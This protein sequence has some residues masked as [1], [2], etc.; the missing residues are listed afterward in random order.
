MQHVIVLLTFI[1]V[2]SVGITFFWYV[3]ILSELVMDDLLMLDG[4]SLGPT[5]AYLLIVGDD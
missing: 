1:N 3:A 2:H 4:H 5:L